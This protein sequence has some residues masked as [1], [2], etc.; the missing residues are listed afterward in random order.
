MKSKEQKIIDKTIKKALKNNAIKKLVY[1]VYSHCSQYEDYSFEI[2]EGG[3]DI[4]CPYSLTINV[5]T[6]ILKGGKKIHPMEIQ[7][8]K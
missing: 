7:D 1:E 6:G 4:Y 5:I 3:D 2:C 8:E